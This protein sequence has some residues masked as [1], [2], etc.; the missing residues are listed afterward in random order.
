MLSM[1]C[2]WKNMNMTISG[3]VLGNGV[4]VSNISGAT[5][6]YVK[7]TMVVP[8]GATGL[9]FVTSGGTG[10]ADMYVRLGS[11]PTTTTTTGRGSG[12]P[13]RRGSR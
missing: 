9:K 5:G 3:N 1:I 7:Y 12:R 6:A 10:D 13:R 2:R 4:T 8:A 11:A